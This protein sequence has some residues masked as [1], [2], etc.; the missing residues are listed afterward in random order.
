[1]IW[2]FLIWFVIIGGMEPR[3]EQEGLGDIEENFPRNKV[4]IIEKNIANKDPKT[5]HDKI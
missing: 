3:E 4:E 1:M 5:I 2:V